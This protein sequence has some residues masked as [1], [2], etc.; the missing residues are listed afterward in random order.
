LNRQHRHLG[1][2]DQ[3]VAMERGG[4]TNRT[5]RRRERGAVL[6]H[7]AVILGGLVSFSALTIDYGVLWTS[8]RQAQ[9]SADA[10]ALAGAIALA[11][12]NPTDKSVTGP[13]SRNAFAAT[14]ANLV[15]GAAPSVTPATDITFNTCPDGTDTC[16]Q[17]RVYRTSAR[18]SALPS[19]FAQLIGITSQDIQAYAEAEVVYGN[20]TECM[21]PFAVLDKWDEFDMATNPNTPESEY[22]NGLL[23]PDWNINSTFDKYPKTPNA[24]TEPDYYEAPALCPPG[25]TNC[26]TGTGYRLFD[27]YGNAVD[28]G[29]ELKLHTGS[30]DQTSPGWFLPV[31]LTPTASGAADYCSAIKQ[32]TGQLNSIGQTISTENGNMVGPTEACLFTDADSLYN[33]D[34]TAHWEPDYFGTGRGA[35]V[36]SKYGPNQSPRIVPMPVINPDELFAGDPNGQTTL[37]IR[38]I[39]GFFVERQEG[40]GGQTRT[41]GRLVNVPGQTTGGNTVDSSSSFIKTIRLIR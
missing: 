39:L 26:A 32:C 33:K 37:T 21:R 30:Q 5:P 22:L 29:T 17:V 36:S 8:R 28:Y 13:A 1:D 14:Q 35:V 20:A 25:T 27:D 15:F 38:N 16:V 31:R 3:E 19:F 9:N 24:P 2:T 41:V 10:G 7:V 6:V 34:P 23:D 18:G 40:N 12:D 11:F 4:V